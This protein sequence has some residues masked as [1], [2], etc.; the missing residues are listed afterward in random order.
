MKNNIKYLLLPFLAIIIYSCEEDNSSLDYYDLSAN[1]ILAD[2]KISVLDKNVDLEINL[3]TTEEVLVNSIEVFK[4]G[5][6][7]GDATIDGT[8]ALFNTSNL[9]P[10]LFENSKTKEFTDL[11]GSFDVS[12]YS[13]LSNGKFINQDS[14]VTVVK[15]ITMVDELASVKYLD[16]TSQIISFKTFTAHATI[17]EVIVQW[18]KNKTGTYVEDASKTLSTT[19]DYI[20]LGELDYI[21]DYGLAIKDTVY[22]KFIAKSGVFTDEVTTSIAINTQTMNA[23]LSFELSSLT[24]G[25]MNLFNFETQ[26]RVDA[27]IEY[28]SL[29]FKVSDGANIEFV[30]IS[31]VDIDAYFAVGDLFDSEA[32]FLAGT[33]ETSFSNVSVD[34]IFA[35]KTTRMIRVEDDETND[36]FED[37]VFYGLLKVNLLKEISGEYVLGFDFRDGNLIRE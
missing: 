12:L 7:I 35:Y 37:V 15:A 10:F 19:K 16:T 33:P 23:S 6:K 2:T 24:D 36:V 11:T 27:E 22:Y 31:P 14:P 3:L 4:D 13:T 30:K 18:K 29:G 17:D 28:Q 5:T 1:V 20:N 9:T 34:D 21:N 32:D 26:K 25:K 8:T